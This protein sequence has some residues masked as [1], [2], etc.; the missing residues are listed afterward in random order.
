M[1]IKQSNEG[2]QELVIL[3]LYFLYSDIIFTNT[4]MFSNIQVRCNKL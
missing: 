4:S 1:G 2:M 3:T